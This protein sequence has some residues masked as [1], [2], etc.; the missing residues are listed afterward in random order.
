ME[1]TVPESLEPLAPL[2]TPAQLAWQR[3]AFA[4]F[5][6]FGTNTF[7]H[8][9]WGDGQAPASVFNPAALDA[10]QWA[11]AAQA[12]GAKAMV[13]TAKHHDGFCLWPSA[14]T[15]YSVKSSPWRNGQGDV[16]RDF[17]DACRRHGLVPGLYLSPWDRH[18]P[19]Y[20]DSAAYNAFYL[21]QLEELLTRYGELGE[22]WFDGACGEGANGK[23]QQYDWNAFFETCRRLQPHAVTF[24][25]GGT[26]VRWI[27][28]ERGVAG[29]PNWCAVDASL[30]RFPGDA[31]AD[32]PMDARA[33]QLAMA[34][35]LQHGT[36]DGDVWRPGE[37]DVSIRPG[38]FH[39]AEEDG[40]VRS[41]SNLV[42][43][44]FRSIGRNASLL[45]NVPPTP[46]GRFHDTDVKRLQEFGRR[47][48][49]LFANDVFA[50]ARVEAAGDA[51][52]VVLPEPR[53]FGIL[54]LA[55]PIALGQRVARHCVRYREAS[56]AWAWLLDGDTIGNQ[57]LHR[58][59]PVVTDRLRVEISRHRGD[60]PAPLSE[61]SAFAG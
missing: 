55:E 59:E 26:D 14:Y 22:I 18:E 3:R 1:I 17:V 58:F 46:A 36:P 7:T 42:D 39:H 6:H 35:Q 43:L 19:A 61:I 52:E 48:A 25:D 45:L 37:V 8:R 49:S 16:V 57:R 34:D 4:I 2:P 10:D 13:L 29:D 56:G 23:R 27:G 50:D 5:V 60:A 47:M 44:H 20:G 51:F 21:A 12:A 53:A 31:G 33:V 11:A 38:W 32:R 24:G 54:R 15:D 41:V 9:E 30:A 28:N 40:C